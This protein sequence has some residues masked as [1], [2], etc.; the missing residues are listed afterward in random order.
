MLLPLELLQEI[1][2]HLDFSSYQNLR[3]SSKWVQLPLCQRLK[4]QEF[5]RRLLLSPTQDLLL[6]G[7]ME[8]E[9]SLA[10]DEILYLLTFKCCSI[11]WRRVIAS[12]L[13]ISTQAI[14]DCFWYLAHQLEAEYSAGD[15]EIPFQNW[16]QNGTFCS[17]QN[18]AVKLS[19]MVSFAIERVPIPPK[20]RDIFLHVSILCGNVSIF[21]QL[22][23]PERITNPNHVLL[24]C[25]SHG[26]VDIVKILLEEFHADPSAQFHAAFV[27]SCGAGDMTLVELLLE[28]P[29]IVP[30]ANENEAICMASAHGNVEVVRK[31][32]DIPTVDPSCN[33]RDVALLMAVK[34]GNTE[35]VKLLLQDEGV[36]PSAE[37]NT[38]LLTAAYCGWD[39]LIQVLLQDPR[40]IVRE[41]LASAIF[42][43]CCSAVEN[44]NVVRMLLEKMEDPISEQGNEYLMEAVANGHYEIVRFLLELQ[45]AHPFFAGSHAFI[46][47]CRDNC[48]QLVQYYLT[49]P[50]F[51]ASVQNNLALI[52]ASANGNM[53]VVRLLLLQPNVHPSATC[54]FVFSKKQCFQPASISEHSLAG[55]YSYFEVCFSYEYQDSS[56]LD[57]WEE[58]VQVSFSEETNETTV[59]IDDDYDDTVYQNTAIRVAIQKGHN[60][61]AQ[62][63]L[64]QLNVDPSWNENELLLCAV[65]CKQI[66]VIKSLLRHPLVDPSVPQQLPFRLACFFAPVE[67]IRMFLDDARV[68]PSVFE[69]EALQIACQE[70]HFDIVQLL[71]LDDGRVN[72]SI[73]IKNC[74]LSATDLKSENIIKLLLSR[75]KPSLDLIHLEYTVA[76]NMPH[77]TELF[78]PHCPELSEEVIHRFLLLAVAC[79]HCDI[80]RF[81]LHKHPNPNKGNQAAMTLAFS[82]GLFDMIRIL[83]ED[84]R[85]QPCTQCPPCSRLQAIQ[86]HYASPEFFY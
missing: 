28:H 16:I 21:Q 3:I 55:G 4:R 85:V 61:I 69:N 29:K 38:S 64:K 62:L 25:C 84:E 9:T 15:V 47:A 31:L 42:Q 7:Q 40:V 17:N 82:A 34:A 12:S 66:D 45:V 56:P 44:V 80:A 5:K 65:E 49:I 6:D 54:N 11:E 78:L 83:L 13:R 57:E 58:K 74:L 51:D 46:A 1:G 8:L 68:N 23:T 53:E 35:I 2:A 86:L 37:N 67:I 27:I 41:H 43:A 76:R 72:P 71:L 26:Y 36:D 60:D 50:G 48:L 79:N 18:V 19:N 59:H 20:S 63:L 75:T 14:A 24:F 22:A 81:L 70:G 32:M 39:D 30:Y 77:I 52:E 33:G 73:G 10:N